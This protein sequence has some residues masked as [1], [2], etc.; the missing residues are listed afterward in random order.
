[1]K[2][3]RELW[4][5]RCTV[6]RVGT[7]N[8]GTITRRG[9]E[10]ADIMER[11]NIGI[12]RLQETKWKSSKARNIEGGYKLFHNEDDGRK[13]GIGIAVREELVKSVLE[14]KRVSAR[15][16]AI[17]LEEKGSRLNIVSVYAPQVNN[18]EWRKK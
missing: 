9:R 1:M 12:L 16:M 3:Q 17:K 7:L 5:G 15:L 11:S 4:K 8:I 6:I 14:V 10:L 13:N 2:R 18:I